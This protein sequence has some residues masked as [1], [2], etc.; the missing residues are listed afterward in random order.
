MKSDAS[1][2]ATRWIVRAKAKAKA[3]AILN[4]NR[5]VT[6]PAPIAGNSIGDPYA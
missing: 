5:T 6:T 1:D 2:A 3:K 4:L